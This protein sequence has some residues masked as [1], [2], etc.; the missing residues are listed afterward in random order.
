MK[1]GDIIVGEFTG[2][3]NEPFSHFILD[4]QLWTPAHPFLYQIE[5]SL[6]HESK[7]VDQVTSYFGMRKISKK[8]DENGILRLA[9]NNNIQFQFG[10]LD[11]G[12][13]PDG[14]Y[15][16][17]T[18]EALKYDIEIA[19]Q[20]GFNL[21]RKHGKIEP[22]RWYYWCDKLGVLVW[23][24]MVSG[25]I[26]GEYGTN[27]SK[28]SAEQFEMEC[29][30]VMNE[31]YNHP[32]IITWI[33]FNEGWGQYDTNR[34]VEWV[35]SMDSTRLVIGASGFV[36]MGNGDIHD[37]HGY[38]GPTGAAPEESR[39]T[40]LGEFGGLGY[41]VKGH[42]W[43]ESKSWGYLNYNNKEELAAGYSKLIHQLHPYV[44]EGI[45][46][47]IYT[48]LTDVE[49]E[50]NGLL[51]YDRAV[52]KM[53][54]EELQ[55]IASELYDF[56]PGAFQFDPVIPTSQGKGQNWRY[57]YEDPGMG[58]EKPGFDYQGWAIGQA[59]FGDPK[60]SNPVIRTEWIT[61]EL[62]L[63]KSFD[64]SGETDK[65]IVLKVFHQFESISHF[66]INGHLVAEGLEHSNAYTIIELDDRAKSL[67]K[68][69]EN[70]FAVY[71]KQNGRRAYFDA[72][73]YFMAAP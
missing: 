73:L 37:V 25:D 16:A 22:A 8:R 4:P 61:P 68:K 29:Q 36:D 39:V 53:K 54:A 70:L 69:G 33:L 50:V 23:Q 62:W 3:V 13:W 34:L 72:G 47:A 41:P 12:W 60:D 2:P 65:R 17:P 15:R 14:L 10:L 9:L 52:V 63:S 40:T 30:G 28:E 21:L 56:R 6:L 27:R 11:Q 18:D 5:I 43:D 64:F 71:C 67:F 42:L 31:L 32:S 48:Q 45:S 55:Q 44:S 19:K 26:T 51:T 66:Y 1:D 35:K 24:D 58:W 59:G 20:L 38:P 46:A 57:V 49:N 7:T